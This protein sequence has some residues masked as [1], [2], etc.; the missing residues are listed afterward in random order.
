MEMFEGWILLKKII[1][2]YSDSGQIW[3]AK[4][5]NHRIETLYISQDAEFNTD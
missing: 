5:Q 1:D 2:T 4:N 3:S